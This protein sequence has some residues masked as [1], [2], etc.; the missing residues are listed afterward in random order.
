[1]RLRA[2]RV[3]LLSNLTGGWLTEREATDPE[4]W[5]AHLTGTVRFADGV[6]ELLREPGRV[7]VEAGPGGSLGTFVRQQAAA[8]GV[9]APP[10][11]ASLP[12]AADDTPEPA[13][14]L[15]ALGRLWTAGV[16]PEWSALAWSGRRCPLPS[17]PA[18]PAPAPAEAEAEDEVADETVRALAEL[19][20]ELLRVEPRPDDD[21]FLLGGDSLVATRLIAG[22]R[23]RFGAE[24]RL[25]TLFQ[26]RTVAAMAR[27]IDDA[28]PVRTTD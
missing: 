24:M 8:C 2:P 16:R 15:G 11:V 5:A 23:E 28:R 22:I 12:H 27:W 18:A 9:A 10:A 1:M 19:W 25:R 21:F 4:Y 20:R 13:F 6:A 3:P 7:V 26:T 17:E 14:A